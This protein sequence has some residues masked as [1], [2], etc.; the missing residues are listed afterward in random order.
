MLPKWLRRISTRPFARKSSTARPRFRPSLD[1][2]EDRVVPAL[3][4]VNTLADIVDSNTAVTSLR[5][6]ILG[7]NAAVGADQIE[8]ASGLTG[9]ITL[10]TGQLTVSDDLSITGP[11]AGVTI[12]GNNAS[13]IFNVNDGS[14]ALIDVE[15]VG[16]TL[17][18]G[19][20][21]VDGAGGGAILNRENLT[22]INCTLSNSNTGIEALFVGGGM[23]NFGTATLTNCILTNNSSELEGGGLYNVGTATLTDCTLSNNSAN[24][25]GGGI[26]N[27]GTATLT[28]CNL[29]NNTAGSGGGL[30]NDG[31]ATLTD[32]TVSGNTAD[33]DDGGGLM[34]F[35]TVTLSDCTLSG[36]SA[37]DF[38]GGL[39]NAGGL[40]NG[41][42]VT[43]T[44][45]ILSSNS[46]SSGGGGL[47]NG[48]TATL[49]DCTL[50]G[51]S[52]SVFANGGGLYNVG[53]AILTDCTL[54]DN[55]ATN[56]GG[57]FN[58]GSATLSDCVLSS[59]SANSGS[60]GG[61]SNEGTAT[62][63]DCTLSSNSAGFGGGLSNVGTIAVTDCTLSGNTGGA[64]GG[65]LANGVGGTATITNSTLLGNSANSFGGGGVLN[66]GTIALTN[67]TVS[68]N[69]ANQGGGLSNAVNLFTGD[70]GTA[71]V[72]NCT[73]SGNTA[74]DGGGVLNIFGSTTL[75]NTIVANSVAAQEIVNNGGTL[76]G[77]HN[78]VE[79]GSGGLAGTIVADPLLG[80]LADYGGPTLT[81]ALLSGSVAADA[82]SNALVPAGVT[83]DQRGANRFVGTV[84]LGAF[85]ADAAPDGTLVVNTLTDT[86]DSDPSVTSL[87]EAILAANAN[88]GPDTITFS[89]AGT[90]NV[91]SQLPAL[92][93]ATGGT[94][95]DGASAPDFTGAPV[96][97]LQGPGTASGLAGLTL[98]SAGNT[99]RGLAVGGF[100]TGI[101]V[102]GAGASGNVIA[103][104][105]VGNNGST[106]VA[107]I[108]GISING[109]SSNRVGTN[110]DG[111]NDAAERNVISGNVAGLGINQATSAF[112]TV[113]GNYVGLT[114]DGESALPNTLGGIVIGVGA[115][116]NVIGGSL[117]ALRNVVSGNGGPG[118]QIDGATTSGNFVLRNYIGTD[119][120]GDQ[121]VGNL[122]GVFIN[123]A[124]E[125]FIGLGGFVGNQGN[126]ISGN[127]LDGIQLDNVGAQSNAIFAN[128]IGLN[129]AGTAALGNGQN[130]I[131]LFSASNNSIGGN[132][133]S[134]NGGSGVVLIG[135]A[136]TQ[137]RI[138]SNS[139]FANTRLG[140]DLGSPADPADGVTPNDSLDADSGANDLQNAPVIHK[141]AAQPSAGTEIAYSLHSTPNTAFTVQFFVSPSADPSGF[142]EGSEFLVQRTVTTNASGKASETFTAAAIP[143]G[144]VVTATATAAT[145]STSEFSNAR[146]VAPQKVWTGAV[147]PKWS[148]AANW[149]GTAPNAG[150]HLVFGPGAPLDTIND[151][152]PGTAFAS[153]SFT[154]GNYTV[155]GNRINLGDGGIT[156]LDGA[157]TLG[158]DFII[159]PICPPVVTAAASQLTLAGVLSGPGGLHKDGAGTVIVTG[160]NTYDGETHVA[161]GVL[162]IENALA[163]GSAAV[164]T[165]VMADAGLELSG[166]IAVDG[167]SLTLNPSSIIAVLQG[168]RSVEGDNSWSGPI[169]LN[170]PPDPDGII[171]PICP[172]IVV[173]PDSRLTLAGPISGA[174]GLHIEGGGAVVLSGANSYTGE[175]HVM[176]ETTVLVNG[177][178]PASQVTVDGG[179]LGGSG[180][181]GRTTVVRGS[182]R[183]GTSPGILTVAGDVTL[184]AGS[185]F[186][187]E[188]NGDTAGA[189][190]DQLNVIGGVDLGNATL[191]VSLGFAP[192]LGDSFLV[193]NNDGTDAIQGT[194][195]GLDED[196]LFTVDGQ[197]FRISYEGGD[198]NDVE[199]TRTGIGLAH[200][201][202]VVHGTDADDTIRI[203]QAG[204]TGALEVLLNDVSQGT[205]TPDA[206]GQ[207]IVRGHRGDDDIEVAGG[208]DLSAWLYG[209]R[210]DDLLKG[211]AGN[212]VLLGGAG[213]DDLSGG[214]GRDL[215]IGG[216]GADR[217]VGNA[218]DDLLIAGLT[219]YDHNRAALSAIMAEW[220]RADRSYQQRIEHLQNGGGLNGSVV[221][222]VNGPGAT[223][224]D[225][226][227]V[228]RL[229][230]SAGRDW[231][232]ANLDCGVLDVITDDR[233]DEQVWDLD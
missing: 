60:G 134:G 48:G 141:A 97:L 12:S 220:G 145:G 27:F 199:L 205:F 195:Q 167:E 153:L 71:T 63:T 126:V 14:A 172:P 173:A 113:A 56:G 191:D 179:I 41:G 223:V 169:N 44:N 38:G 34:N 222:K 2:L 204:D 15:I 52:V 209:G 216:R 94:T 130:G 133:I 83:T 13:R 111:V 80:P 143:L 21:G 162:R 120:D 163:L 10:T 151:F 138:E 114:A 104:N 185:T 116:N 193:V 156:V 50:S 217:L 137:N 230:G 101:L 218:D 28:D 142:G 76:A 72:T 123:N 98:T 58:G 224:F 227:A 177:T 35:G 198:G 212:D 119:K 78:L 154:G 192:A 107:N 128:F 125:N 16:L 22:L 184:A 89:V 57:F 215:L 219:A 171:E 155:G 70:V 166:G 74:P 194:F 183:P 47:S 150:D 51:N 90:I 208:I 68:G 77:S 196:A 20:G 221:L 152:A 228:D 65:G 9:Q 181:V 64:G 32:C 3:F 112:N 73:L 135:A 121:A 7:A 55:D 49:T 100:G 157:V 124:P 46:A 117:V 127:T 26:Y 82:G 164:G 144:Q 108:T 146:L 105:Y 30:F 79:D 91:L 4:V 86:V 186:G 131:R 200:G 24:F 67:C 87:R 92:S 182:L 165:E 1:V 176:E 147:S 206:G 66:I 149:G 213:D 18:G 168:L 62:L 6:A 132:T 106:A 201:N 17:T 109:A 178:Q 158:V 225:D 85:E 39:S 8:F 95:I 229:T 42:T 110:G 33:D 31:T 53:T 40:S 11:A 115:H 136:T 203:V 75:N 187:V 211:G 226:G 202:L 118:I 102:S 180:I 175:T 139:I 188:L 140:I 174:G 84:D 59:N 5:E 189:G 43:L 23:Y 231:F 25:D 122:T 99:V 69:T 197:Q 88:S 207:I 233:D 214:Q 81:H 160:A 29:S 161:E 36:N 148:G 54:S 129:A 210:G 103:G 159:T 37:N 232:F 190:Y 61:F 93:D 19:N 96:V 45:C 170:V